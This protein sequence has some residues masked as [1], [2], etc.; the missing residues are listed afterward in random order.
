MQSNNFFTTV[1]SLL[2]ILLGVNTITATPL[3]KRGGN[4][5]ATFYTPGLGACGEYSK[6]NDMIAAV[7][8]GRSKKECGRRVRVTRGSMSVDVVI[9]DLC[10]GCV[11]SLCSI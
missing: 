3:E 11:S 4:G 10:E 9:K 1:L 8:I 7:A 2:F 5:D 6:S